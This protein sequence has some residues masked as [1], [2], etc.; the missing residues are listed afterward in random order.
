MPKTK[1][2]RGLISYA[3]MKNILNIFHLHCFKLVL[4][5]YGHHVL[6]WIYVHRYYF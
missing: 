3:L 6:L 4:G 2:P 5:V 1:S